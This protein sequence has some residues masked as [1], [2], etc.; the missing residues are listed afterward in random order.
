MF[1]DYTGC[2][3]KVYKTL[4]QIPGT[5]IWGSNSIYLSAKVNGLRYT[6]CQSYYFLKLL[7]VRGFWCQRTTRNLI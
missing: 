5:Q 1:I 7:V 3:W 2:L 4:A 6:E